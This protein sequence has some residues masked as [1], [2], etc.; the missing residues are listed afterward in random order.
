MGGFCFMKYFLYLRINAI[1]S[2]LTCMVF[3]F[4]TMLGNMQ[5]R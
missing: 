5:R 4:Y 2:I 1:V 3:Y